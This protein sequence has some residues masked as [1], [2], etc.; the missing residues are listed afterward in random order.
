MVGRPL[1][2]FSHIFPLPHRSPRRHVA[3]PCGWKTLD[4]IVS[5]TICMYMLYL[6]SLPS[7]PYSPTG[8]LDAMLRGLVVGRL[9]SAGDQEVVS[10]AKRRFQAHCEGS[11]LIPADLRAPVSRGGVVVGRLGNMGWG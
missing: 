5:Y 10:E 6:V 8:P 7:L 2:S 9:G 11:K 3:W 1:T 4:K